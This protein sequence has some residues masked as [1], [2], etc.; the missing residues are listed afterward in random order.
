[1]AH[2]KHV[3]LFLSVLPAGAAEM[4]AMEMKASGIYVAR[5]LCYKDAEF[6][7]IEA[8]LTPEQEKMYDTACHLW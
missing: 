4:M 1:M 6:V 3:G 7:T 2:K 5:G 8:N